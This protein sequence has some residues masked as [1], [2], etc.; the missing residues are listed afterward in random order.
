LVTATIELLKETSVLELSTRA[1]GARAGLDRRAITRQFGG[2]LEL[3]IATLEELHRRSVRAAKNM[4]EETIDYAIEEWE[5]RTNLLA[6]LILSGVDP[7]RL[8]QIEVSHDDENAVLEVIGLDPA[9]PRDIQEAFLALLQA[10]A[11]TGTFF[12][13][14]SPRSNP[15]NRLRIFLMLRYLASLGPDLPGLIGLGDPGDASAG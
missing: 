2:E 11:L 1:I 3:F 14:S 4:P 6:F 7:E 10:V 13:P 15:E 12:G 8:R 9:S 5:I